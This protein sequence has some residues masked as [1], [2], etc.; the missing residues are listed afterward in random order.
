MS[1]QVIN[2][3]D[4]QVQAQIYSPPNLLIVGGVMR[5]GTSMLSMILGSHPRIQ[6]MARELRVFQYRDLST[7]AHLLAVH[8]SL[9]I[10]FFRYRD[11]VFRRQ[12]YKYLYVMLKRH[13]LAE[14]TTI[15]QIHLG[16][17]L[18]LGA[19]NTLYVGDKYPQYL[20][21][22]PEFIHRPNTRCIFIYRDVRDVVAS[23]LER[24]HHGNW[25]HRRRI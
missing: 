19:R 12:A 2:E 9:L 15:D 8:Q 11:A 18:A 10:P 21:Y 16:L 14:H 13:R 20:S 7:W 4:K 1:N 3:Q 23:I 25:R 6:L 22:Y 17:S 24:V 5:G